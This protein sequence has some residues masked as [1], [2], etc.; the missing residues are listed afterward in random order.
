M[1]E[2]LIEAFK[3]KL[4]E[5]DNY[6]DI[7]IEYSSQKFFGGYSF[8]KFHKF[9][10]SQMMWH[11]SISYNYTTFNLEHDEWLELRRLVEEKQSILR[12]TASCKDYSEILEILKK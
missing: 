12:K 5:I 8:I 1:K 4:S 6:N 7:D 10:L 11:K 9:K 2:E 3:K